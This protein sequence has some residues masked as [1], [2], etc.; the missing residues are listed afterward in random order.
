MNQYKIPFSERFAKLEPYFFAAVILLAMAWSFMFFASKSSRRNT[1]TEDGRLIVNYW[2]KW[3]GFE[4]D[5]M[6]AVVDDFNKSQDKIFVKMLTI[7]TID[8][9][10]L[11]SAAGGNP[12]D[13]AGLWAQNVNVFAEKGALT[14]LNKALEK[15]GI[16]KD[17][18][19][20]AL[21][22]LC[23]RKGFVWA[24]PSTPATVALH[25]NKR[26]F[27]EAGLNPDVPPKNRRELD[28]MNEKLTIVEI[29][30][31]GKKVKVRYN[32]LTD[33]ERE[34]KQ[35]DIVQLGYTPTEPGWWN[36]MWSYWFDGSLWDEKGR[37]TS[38]N[39]E[40]IEALQWFKSFGDKYGVQNLRDFGASFGNFS[41]P[42]NPFL[43][44]KVAMVL[45]GVWMYNFIDKFAPQVEWAAAPFPSLSDNPKHPYTTIAEC[46]VLV[47]PKGAPHPQEAFEFISYVNSQGPMEKL[48]FGQ[49][50]FSPLVKYSD[51]FIKK[52]PNPYIKV[53][54]N[55]AK[56]PG[57]RTIPKLPVWN[58]YNNELSVAYDQGFTGIL[59]PEEALKNVK[60]RVQWK[61]D[62]ILRRWDKIKDGRIKEWS[63]ENDT[64]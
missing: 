27:R 22:S 19:I 41:S 18:Y 32:D 6:Q 44:E 50:K 57:A 33:T 23:E 43:S 45:Q 21:W 40:N 63:D 16:K 2:E 17:N 55:L 61:M 53:F 11:L 46:D 34:K 64:W 1:H 28:A 37:I 13:V 10:L 39:K 30:R 48:N 25:W 31:D 29:E 3:T 12:P 49:R 54:I 24:L 42:Q 35:F 20:P 60:E 5:A 52:H 7:S 26:L 8:Q 14:P 58:E 56:D 36:S 51:A 9:K 59:P 4:R 47:I 62:K 38:D 15:K